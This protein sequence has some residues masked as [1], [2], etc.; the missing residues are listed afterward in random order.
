MSN[1][2]STTREDVTVTVTESLNESIFKSLSRIESRLNEVLL[3]MEHIPMAD[4]VN[5]SAT[6]VDPQWLEDVWEER[7]R[8]AVITALRRHRNDPDAQILCDTVVAIL[9]GHN[10]NK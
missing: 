7:I 6:D 1:N 4:S 9:R 5:D 2:I 3:I 8:A 10:D